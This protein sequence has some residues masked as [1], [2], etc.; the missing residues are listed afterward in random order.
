M[1]N[2]VSRPCN[3]L[4]DQEQISQLLVSY[5]LA[6]SLCTYP[7]VWRLRLLLSSRVWDAAQDAR[8][9]ENKAGQVIGLA[10][11]W[12]RQP[13]SPYLV[14][15]RFL[16]PAY[17]N[18]FLVETMLAWGDRRAHDIV[19]PQK[20]DLAVYASGFAPGLGW[21]DP[22]ESFGYKPVVPEPL[23][24][25]VY[26][27]RSLGNDLPEP[28][29]PP[30]YSIHPLRGPEELEAYRSISSFA[31]VNPQHQRELLESDEY[32]FLI[33]VNPQGALVAYCE[34]SICR[35]E[36]QGNKPRIGWIDY[37]ETRAEEQGRGLG[38]AVLYAGLARL[39][40]WGADTVMLVT[41]SGN[42]PAISLYSRTGFVQVS[43]PEAP[44]YEKH[45]TVGDIS[46]EA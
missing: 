26:F 32:S 46:S 20:I 29:L 2:L 45:I 12:R 18:D 39:R 11:L 31:A 17:G 21:R 33:V 38:R 25:N 27:S 3:Y 9:W 6:T 23:D 44:R 36:W 1:E 28:I 15:D 19:D 37:I 34:H 22:L 7:T 42:S 43:V 16:H 10:M 41:V 14:L 4:E 30:G 24:Q 13:A 5:R 40:E 8:I 35:A